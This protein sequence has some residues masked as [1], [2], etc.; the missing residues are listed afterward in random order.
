VHLPPHHAWHALALSPKPAL[1]TLGRPSLAIR[2][3][4]GESSH[5]PKHVLQFPHKVHHK[6]AGLVSGPTRLLPFWRGVGVEHVLRHLL[7]VPAHLRIF[8]IVVDDRRLIAAA[9]EAWSRRQGS[10]GALLNVRT[11]CVRPGTDSSVA[12]ALVHHLASMHVLT[13]LGTTS[14]PAPWGGAQSR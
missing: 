14:I 8:I 2:W 10:A 5:L 1:T 11:T 3:A 4:P 12:A 7:E 13:T 9:G 6:V